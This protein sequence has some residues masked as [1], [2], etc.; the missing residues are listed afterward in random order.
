MSKIK[1][2]SEATGCCAERSRG[3]DMELRDSKSFFFLCH[4]KNN[5]CLLL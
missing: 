1:W 5:N 4:Q 2:S 3:G